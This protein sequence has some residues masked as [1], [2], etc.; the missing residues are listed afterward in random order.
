MRRW[1]ENILHSLRKALGLDSV[2]VEKCLGKRV[3]FLLLF[4]YPT[5]H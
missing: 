4:H 3:S 1:L 5:I 2:V